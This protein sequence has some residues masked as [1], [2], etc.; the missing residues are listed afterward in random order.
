[1]VSAIGR[2]FRSTSAGLAVLSVSALLRAWSYAPWKVDQQRAP[3]HWLESLTAPMV[4]GGVWA[5]IAVVAIA[6]MVR[7]CLLPLAVGM[8]VAM[9]AA[10]CLSFTWQTIIG[11]SPR[12]WVTAISYGSTAL[13]VLWAF[14]RAYP[15]VRI[16]LD[17][18]REPAHGGND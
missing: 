7:R 18:R 8:V 16:D 17:R 12:A 3:V 4:W 14:S 9:H 1:M 10:W 13:L 11:E 15:T 5:V 2:G 6:A